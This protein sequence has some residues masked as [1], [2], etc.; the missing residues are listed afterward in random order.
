[1]NL[2]DYLKERGSQTKL[3]SQIGCAVVTIHQLKEGKLAP[4]AKMALSIER[5]TNGQVTR[6][7]LR[8]DD[9]HLIWPELADPPKTDTT[10]PT[11]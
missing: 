9:W 1:M 4:S 11:R 6:K 10:L 2:K 3:A 5:A 7:D 8:H